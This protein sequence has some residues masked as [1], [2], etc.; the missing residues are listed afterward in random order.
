MINLAMERLLKKGE[1]VDVSEC[2]EVYP[3]VYKLIKTPNVDLD[4]ADIKKERWIWSIG[5]DLETG[6]FYAS[7]DCRFYQNPMFHCVWLR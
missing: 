6:A 3:G 4:Y 7:V 5:Q 2:E 1:L